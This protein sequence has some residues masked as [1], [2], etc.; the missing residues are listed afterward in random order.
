MDISIDK[1]KKHA[2]SIIGI[3]ILVVFLVLVWKDYRASSSYTPVVI[4]QKSEYYENKKHEI[5][6]ASLAAILEAKDLKKQYVDLYEEYEK[7]KKDK[8]LVITNTIT[9]TKI[10]SIPIPTVVSAD[11][12]TFDWTWNKEFDKSN[13]VHI[14]GQ[15]KMDSVLNEASTLMKTLKIG[16]DL[17]VDFI[18]NEDYPSTLKVIA[19]SNN[20]YVSVV[21]TEGA[22]IDPAKHP[23][24]KQIIKSK[25]KKWH[26]G[27]Q[28]GFGVSYDM[29]HKQFGYGPYIGVGVTKSI[30]GF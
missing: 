4:N 18:S 13:Y 15:T 30:I 19:R 16:S 12:K 28:G 10:D 22:I 23:A 8:P 3:A 21:N 17:K 29:Y 2:K 7:L 26:I 25:Q 20:P 6:K 9:E 27:I 1:I 5:Y 11:G 24:F 14:E